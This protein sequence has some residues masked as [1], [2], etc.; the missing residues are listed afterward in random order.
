MESRYAEEQEY[1]R[2][3]DDPATTR[4]RSG[5]DLF[6]T[7]ASSFLA[8]GSTVFFDAAVD[9]MQTTCM[10]EVTMNSTFHKE[11]GEESIL[12]KVFK[13]VCP[14]GCRRKGDCVD[15]QC[16]CHANYS[17]SD[18]SVD[19][20]SPPQLTGVDF[21][22]LCDVNEDPCTAISLVGGTFV[23]SASTTCIF[24]DVDENGGQTMETSDGP[25]DVSVVT[26]NFENLFEL[27]CRIPVRR[28]KRSALGVSAEDK[29]SAYHVSVSNNGVAYSEERIVGIYN[30]ICQ[31]CTLS[32][33]S[34]HLQQLHENVGRVDPNHVTS[35]HHIFLKQ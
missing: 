25:V 33:T 14:S 26:A 19:L 10:Q 29:P 22:G 7:V 20:N 21:D 24:R 11:T 30:S 1:T 32:D 5:I 17:G 12:D 3:G 15:G 9:N 13:V 6:K 31:T 16:K 23:N 34:F 18:C 8:S 27:S 2:R 35:L 4:R 28:T